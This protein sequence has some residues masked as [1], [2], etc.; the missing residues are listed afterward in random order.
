MKIST[1]AFLILIM[2]FTPV[3]GQE[4]R[5]KDSVFSDYLN[6]SA[7]EGLISIPGLS[8]SSSMGVSFSSNGYQSAGMGYYMGHFNYEFSS[9]WNLHMD[10]GVGSVFS[11]D[12]NG[13]SPQFYIP[14]IDLT[15]R[16]DDRNFMLKFQFRQYRDPYFMRRYR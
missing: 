1:I 12:M 10:V 7:G 13:S 6:N 8:F 2:L 4:S 14:N 11:R 9:S 5:L 16:P 3:Y 15:Y